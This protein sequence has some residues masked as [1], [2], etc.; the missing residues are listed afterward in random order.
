MKIFAIRDETAITKKDI[1]YLIYYE[2]DKRFYI[3]LPENADPW[4]TPL[5]LSSFL[6][7]GETTINAYWSK[8]WVQQR[9]IPSDRQNLGQILK[10]NKME[11]YDEFRLLMMANGRCAQD[12]YYLVPIREEDLPQS[13]VKRFQKK[14]EDVVPLTENQ[15][16][17]FF[18]DGNVKKCDTGLFLNSEPRFSRI[19]QNESIFRSVGIQPGG[20]GVCWGEEF[21]IQDDVLYDCGKDVPLSIEDF[22]SFVESRIVNTAEAAELLECSRQNI[23]DLIHRK[24]LHPVKV[25]PRNKLFL[26]SEIVQRKWM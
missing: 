6:K 11:D 5:L 2:R 19:W 15:L 12:D 8:V 20:Y 9:I 21:N 17:V 24:K 3:E 22:R 1:A 4:D 18:R 7:R 26:K 23:E 13:F 14:V 10:E 25:S 16:L